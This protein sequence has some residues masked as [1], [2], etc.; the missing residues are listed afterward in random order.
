MPFSF[1]RYHTP[2]PCSAKGSAFFCRKGVQGMRATS[3][4]Y[5]EFLR[6]RPAIKG[7][8]GHIYSIVQHHPCTVSG[9]F[10]RLHHTPHNIENLNGYFGRI[11]VGECHIPV[12]TGYCEICIVFLDTA[13]RRG[14]GSPFV[15]IVETSVGC[16][17]FSEH[18]HRYS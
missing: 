10:Y 16:D 18:L 14:Q 9:L 8:P 4:P 5:Y 15:T 6:T 2:A 13:Y 1:V 11:I 12:G 17:I 3:L 7:I